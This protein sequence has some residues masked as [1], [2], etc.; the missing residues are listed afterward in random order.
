VIAF[1]ISNRYY[2]LAPAISAALGDLGLT[3]LHREGHGTGDGEIPSQWLAASRSSERISGFRAL[4]WED[5]IPAD[6]PFTD[7][8]ADL[9]SYLRLG[10]EVTPQ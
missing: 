9:L 6:H 1:H 3:T 10:T 7:D 5:A 2:D 4:G 8:Y